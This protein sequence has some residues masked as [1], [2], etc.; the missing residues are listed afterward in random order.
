[1]KNVPEALRKYTGRSPLIDTPVKQVGYA[2]SLHGSQMIY[3]EGTYDWHQKI[4]QIVLNKETADFIYRDFT[5]LEIDYKPGSRPLLERTVARLCA[6]KKTDR[7]KVLAIVDYVYRGR[8]KENVDLFPGRH[9]NV[10]NALEEEIPKVGH[11]SCEC[12]TRLIICLAQIAGFPARYAGSYTYIDPA[13]NYAVDG[14]H[15]MAEI[16]VDSKWSLFDS[17]IGFFC[18]KKDNTIASLWDLEQDLS[19][20]ENQPDWVYTAF[21]RDRKWHLAFRKTFLSPHSV[22]SFSNYSVND[23]LQFDWRWIFLSDDPNDKVV[24]QIGR[25]RQELKQK[26]IK[27]LL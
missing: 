21:G 12:N 5:P 18:V 27:E 4:H 10:L 20:V 22:K 2:I 9:V 13:N 17:D 23:Y 11:V 14:G 6:G 25:E 16:F 1:M 15:A 8:Y 24:A 7:E 3:K 26:L 19:L